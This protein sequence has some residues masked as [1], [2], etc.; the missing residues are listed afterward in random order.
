[1]DDHLLL[2]TTAV[3][4]PRRIGVLYFLG[5]LLAAS[6]LTGCEWIRMRLDPALADVPALKA[7][8]WRMSTTPVRFGQWQTTELKVGSVKTHARRAST[9]KSFEEYQEL[10][11]PYHFVLPTPSGTITADCVAIARFG[12][13][14]S[15]GGAEGAIEVDLAQRDKQ[16]KFHCRYSGAAEGTLTL[17]EEIKLGDPMSGDLEF[18]ADRW[19]VNSTSATENKLIAAPGSLIGYEIRGDNRVVAAVEV[20][21]SGRVW[22]SPASSQ[23]DQDRFAA[24]I[25]AL[26]IY[27]EIEPTEHD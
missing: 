18:G 9:G 3:E 17:T 5:V 15:F 8:Q 2:C 19:K 16:P 1:M 7:N 24:A 22:I 25:T 11:Q 27:R 4:R 14:N 6:I 13:F 21:N 10:E 12:L 20:I 26:L 23:L